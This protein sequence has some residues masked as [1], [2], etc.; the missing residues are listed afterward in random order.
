MESSVPKHL[1]WILVLLLATAYSVGIQSP[2]DRPTL[3]AQRR[4]CGERESALGICVYMYSEDPSR[5]RVAEQWNTSRV[6]DP[7]TRC[8]GIYAWL[9][10]GLQHLLNS[11]LPSHLCALPQPRHCCHSGPQIMEVIRSRGQPNHNV[12]HHPATTLSNDFE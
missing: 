11:L 10:R 12:Y 2:T 8:M 7:F 1:P 3:F 9:S 6:L 4:E 5:T